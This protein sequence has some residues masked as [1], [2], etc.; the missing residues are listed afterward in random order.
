MSANGGPIN[1]DKDI[2]GDDD[3]IWGGNGDMMSGTSTVKQ[4]IHGGDGND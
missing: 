2:W 1:L 3:I 4:T